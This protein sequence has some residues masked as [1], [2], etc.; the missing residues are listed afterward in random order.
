V[1]LVLD[2][3]SG[4]PVSR[5]FY[6]LSTKLETLDWD[7]STWYH[8]PTRTFADYTALNSLPQVGLKA[9]SRTEERGTDRVTTVTLANPGSNGK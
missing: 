7:K 1:S 6:W 3:P 9:T 4:D 5:N 2:D 8:T